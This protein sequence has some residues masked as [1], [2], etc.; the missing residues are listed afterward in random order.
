MNRA[1]V[2]WWARNAHA[3]TPGTARE[4]AARA[5]AMLGHPVS[6]DTARRQC[7]RLGALVLRE[8]VDWADRVVELGD[9][10]DRVI[11]ERHGVTEV[12]VWNARHARGIRAYMPERARRNIRWA[13]VDLSLQTA[14][15][16]CILG[17]SRS[18]VTRAKRAA[19]AAGGV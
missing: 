15:I 14:Q 19:R 9:A 11:A 18:A 1:P 13:D 3:I 12:A 5:S 6:L 2:G 16:M 4:I 10:P 7:V 8:R 17:V